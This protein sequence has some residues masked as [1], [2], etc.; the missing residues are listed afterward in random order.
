MWSFV[1]AAAKNVLKCARLCLRWKVW[2]KDLVFSLHRQLPGRF[3]TP[4]L[5][6][7]LRGATHT[8]TRADIKAKLGVT[9]CTGVR[10]QA[11]T[12]TSDA[13]PMGNTHPTHTHGKTVRVA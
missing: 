2:H 11:F 6:N 9:V 1:L 10:G 3:Y 13:R 8:H 7:T 12:G 4:S 5:S